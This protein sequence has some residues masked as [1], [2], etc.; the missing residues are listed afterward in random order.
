MF[1]FPILNHAKAK[2]LGG[3][4]LIPAAICATFFHRMRAKHATALKL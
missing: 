1:S 2:P 3:S 4:T